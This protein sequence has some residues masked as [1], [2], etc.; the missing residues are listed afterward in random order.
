MACSPPGS[1]VHGILQARIL[2]WEAIASSRGSSQP[3]DPTWVSCIAGG[4]FPTSAT[5]EAAF[6]KITGFLTVTFHTMFWWA[7]RLQTQVDILS[8]T[9]KSHLPGRCPHSMSYQHP[10]IG[11]LGQPLAW[12]C[13]GLFP[14]A[15]PCHSVSEPCWPTHPQA[16]LLPVTVCLSH[17]GSGTC[18]FCGHWGHFTSLHPL[19]PS[20]GKHFKMFCV[21]VHTV[22]LTTSSY[23]FS[24]AEF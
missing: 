24:S 3:K 15:T 4:F 21:I 10:L 13:I 5:W 1:S 12:A 19:V 8:L 2:K 7:P 17:P 11:W 18:C 14:P 23:M 20:P 22:E 6:N 9:P 16:S